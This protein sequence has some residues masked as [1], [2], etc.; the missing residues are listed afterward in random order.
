MLRLR[1]KEELRGN[2]KVA[3]KF[4]ASGTG[5]VTLGLTIVKDRLF[6]RYKENI[7]DF[8]LE[9][10]LWYVMC[11]LKDTREHPVSKETLQSVPE[12]EPASL[13][14]TAHACLAARTDMMQKYRVQGGIPCIFTEEQLRHYQQWWEL[15]RLALKDC[16]GKKFH[17]TTS[18]R[19]TSGMCDNTISFI[20]QRLKD[21][22]IQR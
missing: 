2:T 21:F 20:E 14:L 12:G 15:L 5:I 3:V 16:P 19:I 6:K 7:E 11:F 22:A 10:T 18:E 13:W 8:L 1:A 9:N 4:R 17:L